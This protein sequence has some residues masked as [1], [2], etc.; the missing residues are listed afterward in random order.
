[1]TKPLTRR[2]V[3]ET[4]VQL[5]YEYLEAGGHDPVAILGSQRPEV[6]GLGLG[7]FRIEHWVELLNRASHYLDDPM[8]GLKLGQTITPRHLGVIGYLM[9]GMPNLAAA[10]QRLQH[11]H[12]LVYDVMPMTLHAGPGY[13][14]LAW[15]T[16]QGRP[17]RLAGDTSITALVHYTRSITCEPITIESIDFFYDPPPDLQPYLDYFGCPVR[18]GQDMTR[19]R[20]RPEILGLSLKATDSGL[21]AM[22]EQQAERL[23]AQLPQEEPIIDQVRKAT[24]RLLHEG[25]PNVSTVAAS[26]DCSARTLQRKLHMNGTGF[27]QELATVRQQLAEAYLRDSHLAIADIALLLGYSEQSAFTRS[28]KDWTGESPQHWRSAS[29]H[30]D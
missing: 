25:E 15:G 19:V 14:E 3:P 20:V 2:M 22:M 16:E 21:T 1:M 28:F 27:R 11:Y 29:K 10:L 18:F 23:L 13:I 5:L 7:G 30:L 26:L 17:G 6:P 8:L 12:R 9:M 4:F 24:A